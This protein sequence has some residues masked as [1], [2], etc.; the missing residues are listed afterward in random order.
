MY[1]PAAPNEIRVKITNK[2]DPKAH[3]GPRSRLSIVFVPEK[4]KKICFVK[5]LHIIIAYFLFH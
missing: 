2:Y 4:K 3:E 1:I 5:F